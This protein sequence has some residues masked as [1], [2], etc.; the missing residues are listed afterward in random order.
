MFSPLGYVNA[1][2]A[3][4]VHVNGK[5]KCIAGIG[6]PGVLS[7]IL[8]WVLGESDGRRRGRGRVGLR[9]GGLVTRAEEFVDWFQRNLRK[10][11]E[12]T[13]RLVEA[14]GVDTPRSRRRA[15]PTQRRR[16]QQAYVRRMAKQF[17]WKVQTQR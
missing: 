13:I 16:Q 7:I 12:V 4:E 5:R 2:L 9:V 15:S 1:M 8:T 11:D 3:F 14:A 17:G 10:G 6:E